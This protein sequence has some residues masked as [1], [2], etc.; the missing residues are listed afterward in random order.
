MVDAV[1]VAELFFEVQARPIR[2]LVRAIW[3]SRARL[4]SVSLFSPVRSAQRPARHCAGVMSFAAPGSGLGVHR[5]EGAVD[6][7]HDV[8]RVKADAGL[9]NMVAGGC[10]VGRGHVHADRFDLG[11]G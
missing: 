3:L 2:R 8:E 7:L 9:G 10:G 5:V 11:Q 1:E 4:S 6:P